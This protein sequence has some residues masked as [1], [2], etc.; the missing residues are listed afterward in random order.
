MENPYPTAATCE[1]DS[2][3]PLTDKANDI[4]GEAKF[5]SRNESDSDNAS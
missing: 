4:L 1:I 3:L 5:Q 2:R